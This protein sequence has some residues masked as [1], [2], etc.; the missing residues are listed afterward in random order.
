MSLIGCDVRES[1]FEAAGLHWNQG[2]IEL[3]LKPAQSRTEAVFGVENRSDRTVKIHHVESDCGCMVAASA[4]RTL[5]PKEMSE[6]KVEF[7]PT[8]AMGGTVQKRQLRVHIEGQE[9]P[10]SL[11]LE[12]TVPHTLRVEPAALEWAEGSQATTQLSVE[13][14]VPFQIVGIKSSSNAFVW[15]PINVS[16]AAKRHQIEVRPFS[17]EGKQ[18]MLFIQTT[19]PAP[20]AQIGVPLKVT[21]G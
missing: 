17:K 16:R 3:T 14:A 18:S 21:G 10:V 8:P 4:G 7:R 9:K 1:S 19:L 2:L 5:A 6:V 11:Q 12:V 20:W 13:G 15:K